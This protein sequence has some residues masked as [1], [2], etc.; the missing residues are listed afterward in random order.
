M[1]RHVIVASLIAVFGAHVVAIAGDDPPC[2]TRAGDGC[3][4][5]TA[6]KAA[7]D[8]H[9]IIM[10]PGNDGIL[11]IAMNSGSQP[12]CGDCVWTLII[13]CVH[14]SPDNPH[15]QVPCIGAGQSQKCGK[16]QTLYRLF[17]ATD[18]EANHL[19]TTLCLG[20]P[21]DV[22]DVSNVAATDI[23]KYLKDVKPP[24]MHIG[25]QPPTNALAGIPTYFQVTSPNPAP[26]QFGGA[27]VTETITISPASYTW[28]WGDGSDPLKTTDP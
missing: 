10:V 5:V 1:M 6:D 2:V 23:D 4:G 7:G 11:D 21:Q 20:G 15:N 28:E 25:T 16:G 14:D 17:L 13:A 24:L 8:F 18:T 9:G 19:V 12:G 27:P 26:Q 22:V 3:G